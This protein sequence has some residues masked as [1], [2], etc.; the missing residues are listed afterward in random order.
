MIEFEC[1]QCGTSLRV[2][3]RHAGRTAWCRRCKRPVLVPANAA[4]VAEPAEELP[5][6]VPPV[7][8]APKPYFGASQPPPAY[9]AEE[10]L[11]PVMP[12]RGP[13]QAMETDPRSLTLMAEIERRGKVIAQLTAEVEALRQAAE[14]RAREGDLLEAE[15][16]AARKMALSGVQDTGRERAMFE[17]LNAIINTQREML[18]E[19]DEKLYALDAALRR[20]ARYSEDANGSSTLPE[21]VS[22]P[23]GLDPMP[24]GEPGAE[25]ADARANVNLDEAR[26]LAQH[27]ASEV[28]TLRNALD[29]M[30]AKFDR[31]TVELR[32][33][34]LKLTETKQE[35]E[36]LTAELAAARDHL[37]E[38]D[39]EIERSRLEITEGAASEEAAV[40]PAPAAAPVEV[41]SE[42]VWTAT[43]ASRPEP[44]A[45]YNPPAAKAA[46]EPSELPVSDVQHD[47]RVL[48]DALLRFLGRR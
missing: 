27:R 35:N 8:P 6:P 18:V 33:A 3:N 7:A 43:L 44:A 10:S 14:S 13:I 45:P 29:D 22:E 40:A 23:P 41:L 4:P 16:A 46:P 36:R 15:L 30:A 31:V 5:T 2:E 24:E 26:R 48:V 47:Q 39:L 25:T 42:P 1:M 21:L 12:R 9:E 11:P 32:N 19:K 20:A 17:E 38:R 34:V 28:R 37:R